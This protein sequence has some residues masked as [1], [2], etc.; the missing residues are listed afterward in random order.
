MSPFYNTILCLFFTLYLYERSR[1]GLQNVRDILLR[2]TLNWS[3]I[4]FC[5]NGSTQSNNNRNEKFFRYTK[6]NFLFLT[7]FFLRPMTLSISQ[8]MKPRN[9]TFSLQ[10]KSVSKKEF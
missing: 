4:V 6:L 2:C 8:Y 10:T 1:E 7:F 9:L 3:S 5:T